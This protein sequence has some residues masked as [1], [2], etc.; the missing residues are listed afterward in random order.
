M[1]DRSAYAI[2]I[3]IMVAGGLVSYGLARA[4]EPQSSWLWCRIGNVC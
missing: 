3:M 1:S 4:G 2:I